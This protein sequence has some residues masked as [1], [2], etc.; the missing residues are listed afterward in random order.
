MSVVSIA[1]LKSRFQSGDF[2]TEQ[3]FIDLIDT[4]ENG[5]TSVYKRYVALV[6]QSGTNA[7]TVIELENTLGASPAWSYEDVGIYNIIL[8]NAFTVNKT[9]FSSVPI[10][11]VGDGG[12]L[13]YISSSEI[14]LQIGSNDLLN[15]TP[16]EIRVY[17]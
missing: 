8:S 4:L 16:I 9:W 12:F 10:L 15:K 13:E 2:P 7:P 14:N 3:D 1:Y 17:P 5:S 11:V 6:S